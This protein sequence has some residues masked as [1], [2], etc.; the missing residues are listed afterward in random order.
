MARPVC[1]T[2][3]RE[4]RL[5]EAGVYVEYTRGT[6]DNPYQIYAGDLWECPDCQREILSGFGLT[7]IS[8][9]FEPDY[10]AM[11]ELCLLSVPERLRGS[12]ER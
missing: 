5:K 11:K 1:V 7:P 4:F 12:G 2:C 10:T 3:R 6:A 9:H 8:E